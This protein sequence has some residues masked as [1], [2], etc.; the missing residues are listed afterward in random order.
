MRKV[1][2]PVFMLVLAAGP[3]PGA[4]PLTRA[5]VESLAARYRFFVVLEPTA[6]KPLRYVYADVGQHI[7]VVALKDGKMTP[8][9]DSVGLGSQIT[10]F[11]VKDVDL[12]GTMEIVVSTLQGR[13]LAYDADDYS[14]TFENMLREFKTITCMVAANIDNDPQDEVIFLADSRL[15]VF[16]AL[17]RRQEWETSE[18]YTATMMLVAN[19]DEDEQLEI[20]LNTGV[21]IDSRFRNLDIAIPQAFA[22]RIA[23]QDLNND[24]IPEVIGELPDFSLKIFDLRT[25]REIW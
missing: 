4:E 17:T 25:R 3:T 13:V 12:D 9:W 15:Q 23:L 10:S 21:V 1:I 7:H 19:V 18:N 6:K 8:E 2:L 22:P 14:L 11:F 20:I 16:D 24:G 5:A